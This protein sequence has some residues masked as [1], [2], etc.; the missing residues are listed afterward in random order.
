MDGMKNYCFILIITL[1]SLN[2]S[3]SKGIDFHNDNLYE[4]LQI[5]KAKGKY[6]FIDTYAQWCAPCKRMNKVFD[7]PRVASVYNKEFVNVK[8]NMEGRLGRHMLRKYDVVWLPTL[9]ILDQEGN[10]KYRVD[11]EMKAEEMLQMAQQALDPNFN[12]QET[13]LYS[14]SP[15]VNTVTNLPISKNTNTQS[16][17]KEEETVVGVKDVPTESEK[18]LY[19]LDEKST[20]DNPDILYHEAYLYM[21][22]ADPKMYKAADKYMS[23]QSNWATEKNVR[24]IFN[25]VENTKSKYFPFFCSNLLLFEKYLGKE[26]VRQNLEYIVFTRLN[27]G[28]PRPNLAESIG[29]YKI[30]DKDNGE[31]RGYLYYLNGLKLDDNHIEFMK[32]AERYIR[33]V[34]PFNVAVL[35]GFIERKLSL[36]QNELH[37]CL[38]FIDRA[39]EKDNNNPE[40]LLLKSKVQFQVNNYRKARKLAERALNEALE[41][42]SDTDKIEEMISKL[43]RN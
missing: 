4:A 11:N 21:Q 27:S 19:V 26:K 37:D 33:F 7:D 2:T 10:V 20:S 5:A 34:N 9:L 23:S 1:V 32:V 24:F 6:V 28:Y 8:I 39:L 40:L 29:L 14:T 17:E 41:R 42:N 18:I 12:F 35:E 15:V 43:S 22:L 16:D 31:D 25:F 36:D 38:T 3:H 30:L 13:P